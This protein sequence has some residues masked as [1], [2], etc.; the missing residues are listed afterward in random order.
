MW[1]AAGRLNDDA[2]DGARRL[3]RLYHHDS[4]S[5]PG[6]E[7]DWNSVECFDLIYLRRWGPRY[8]RQGGVAVPG[9]LL[10]YLKGEGCGRTRVVLVTHF[11]FL[12][13]SM[14]I[15]YFFFFLNFFYYYSFLYCF[16]H[17]STSCCISLR[18]WIFTYIYVLSWI[19]FYVHALF[20]SSLF[21]YI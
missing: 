7:G 12:E 4:K 2:R 3:Q 20:Y 6:V 18:S 10:W 5:I 14:Y 21:L 16:S 13:S 15:Q 11:N 9:L 8:I 19:I 1:S 17:Y